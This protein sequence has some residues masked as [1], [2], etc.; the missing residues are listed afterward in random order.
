LDVARLARYVPLDGINL[1]VGASHAPDVLITTPGLA[2]S[3][4]ANSNPRRFEVQLTPHLA[5]IAA[6]AGPEHPSPPA[7]PSPHPPPPPAVEPPWAARLAANAPQA[8]ASPVLTT[9][10]ASTA[11]HQA[12]LAIAGL[13]TQADGRQV[14][15]IDAD[16][17]T[18]THQVPL[19]PAARDVAATE[20]R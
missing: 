8:P 17:A 1:A 18:T 12:V 20:S 4:P 7:P 5:P 19:P 15:G 9:L 3:S 14:V 16:L 2:A 13:P 10:A 11:A 6:R